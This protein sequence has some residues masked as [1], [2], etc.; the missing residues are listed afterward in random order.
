MFT[1]YPDERILP[2]SVYP[3]HIILR[4]SMLTQYCQDISLQ[5][6]QNSSCA[7]KKFQGN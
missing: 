3:T 1:D 7:A 2:T 6:I 4:K 5:A